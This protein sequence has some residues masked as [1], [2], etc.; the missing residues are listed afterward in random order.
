MMTETVKHEWIPDA[1]H[2]VYGRCSCG[3]FGGGY[4]VLKERWAQHAQ[5]LASL[6]PQT[7]EPPAITDTQ[8]LDWMESHI[9]DMY[10]LDGGGFRVIPI[11]AQWEDSP[12]IREAVDAAR[13]AAQQKEEGVDKTPV[14]KLRTFCGEHN[15]LKQFCEH[16]HPSFRQ[17]LQVLI[18][19]WHAMALE[20]KTYSGN[21]SR[22]S[23]LQ[24]C[25]EEVR[26]LLDGPK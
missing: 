21:D 24:D 11:E 18:D 13:E 15:C 9:Q 23:A 5:H 17:R 1:N 3:A 22:S 19:H 4:Y 16:S 7:H 2:S 12:T 25:Y 20:A 8:R 26:D 6:T 14:N 10:A